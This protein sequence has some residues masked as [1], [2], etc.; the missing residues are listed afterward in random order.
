MNGPAVLLRLAAA[1]VLGGFI[2]LEREMKHR[3]AGF[4][5]HILICMGAAITT[6]TSQFLCLEAGFST[7]LARLGAQVIS[8]VG[9]IGAGAIIV[10][11][12]NRI[13]GLTTAAGLWVCA[14]IGLACGAGFI[15]CALIAS[16]VILLAE[17]LLIKIENI[18]G[19]QSRESGVYL[20]YREPGELGPLMEE[21]REHSAVITD[22]EISRIAAD[23]PRFCAVILFRAKKRGGKE[24]IMSSLKKNAKVLLAEEI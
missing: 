15:E 2:G 22:L 12:Q 18:I 9:F 4:R 19:E 6:M 8:G 11:K 20:E 16:G 24:K 1:M 23:R 7:D 5:T 14:I 17:L 13:K 21:M 10:T 3:A